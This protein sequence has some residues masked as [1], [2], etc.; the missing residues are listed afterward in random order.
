MAVWFRGLSR[1]ETRALLE[2]ML[3]SGRV[4]DLGDIPWNRVETMRAVVSPEV[5]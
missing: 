2:A 3:H 1:D 5:S 4:L